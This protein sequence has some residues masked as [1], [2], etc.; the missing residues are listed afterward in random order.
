M[1]P[2]LHDHSTS[3]LLPCSTSALRAGFE[4]DGGEL[5][6]RFSFFFVGVELFAGEVR[7]AGTSASSSSSSSGMVRNTD[8]NSFSSFL[9]NLPAAWAQRVG[10][11]SRLT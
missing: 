2:E 10:F 8:A 7:L 3:E 9:D 4:V 11:L 6:G 5:L 1:N